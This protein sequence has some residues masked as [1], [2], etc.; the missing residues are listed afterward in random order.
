MLVIR[1]AHLKPMTK[2]NINEPPQLT[3]HKAFS[4]HSIRATVGGRIHQ[5][6]QKLTGFSQITPNIQD[7]S[8]Q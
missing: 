4:E 7:Y 6:L 8:Q 2:P 5:F 1:T 3:H